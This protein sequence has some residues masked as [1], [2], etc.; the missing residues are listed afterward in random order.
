MI[1]N[2][3]HKAT[4][5]WQLINKQLLWSVSQAYDEKYSDDTEKVRD[6]F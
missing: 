2:K 3:K 1:M 6:T 4:C 5:F